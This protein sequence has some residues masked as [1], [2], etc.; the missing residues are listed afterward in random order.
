MPFFLSFIRRHVT[1][2][3]LLIFLCITIPFVLESLWHVNSH[4]VSTPAVALDA[5]FISGC[6]EPDV[7]APRENAT[8]LMLARNE[9]IG[10]AIQ[11]VKGWE[12]QF[13]RFFHYPILFLNNEPW[14]KSFIDEL[15][16]IASGPV[17]FETIPKSMWD[18]PAFIDREAARKSIAAQ[19]RQ[20]V[21]K[22]G[23]ESYH[24]MCRFF[25]GL[26]FD[27]AALQGVEYVWRLE[28][29]VVFPCAVPYD[30]FRAM[31]AARKKYGYAIALWEV[32]D[33]APSLFRAAA[34]FK[35]AHR[36]PTSGVWRALASPSWAPWPLRELL[37]A[38]GAHRDAAGARWNQCHF[39]TNFEVAALSWMRSGEYRALFDALDRSG[40]FYFERW[41]DAPVHTLAA[42]MLLR[43]EEMHRFEDLGYG[44]PPFWACPQNAPDGQ[45]PQSLLLGPPDGLS[46]E[47]EGAVGCRCSCFEE[48][49]VANFDGFCIRK[50]DEA[51]RGKKN[52]WW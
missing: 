21:F 49:K 26:F 6:V 1:R 37:G 9:D 8:A 15:S 52:A 47:R 45:L 27:H 23:A 11:T 42:A 22:A 17:A 12:Q 36:L 25:A 24:H 10:G 5:P 33:T 29:D 13:N 31:R 46:A 44:H 2:R 20:G 7:S 4:K 14:S 35:A 39:W 38:A 16:A 18:Y 30:P 28:P 3:R 51:L 19:G 41:G 43:P 32:G 50:F 48:D 40:G 34:A